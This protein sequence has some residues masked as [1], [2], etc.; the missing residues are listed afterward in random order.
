MDR[1]G[2]LGLIVV[3]ALFGAWN[4]YYIRKSQDAAL[5]RQQVETA[6]VV[7]EAANPKPDPTPAPVPPVP[8][9]SVPNTPALEATVSEKIEN[10]SSGAAE[11][12]FTSA[13]GGIKRA[14]LL[15]HFAEKDSKVVLN[16]YGTIAIGDMSEIAGEGLGKPF[17]AQVD[18]AGG[19]VIFDRTDERQVQLTKKFTV[20]KF[21]TLKGD[22]R[23]REESP[24]PARRDS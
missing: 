17:A 12:A 24:R 16:Q 7:A 21:A 23:L 6:A 15:E 3:V 20:P 18:P 8:G 11:Y 4:F 5:A 1:K 10:V 22:D 13:G 2:I 19:T 9:A 14:T